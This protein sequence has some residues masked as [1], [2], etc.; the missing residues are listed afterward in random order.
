MSKPTI[1]DTDVFLHP[2]RMRGRHGNLCSLSDMDENQ[3]GV[4]TG[5]QVEMEFRKNRPS[6]L[7]AREVKGVEGSATAAPAV[8]DERP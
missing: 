2:C 3:D 7:L 5:W 4:T 8:P 6:V 1:I